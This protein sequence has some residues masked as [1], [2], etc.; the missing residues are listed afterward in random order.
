MSEQVSNRRAAVVD[1]VLAAN[2][3]AQ[4]ALAQ[5]IQTGLESIHRVLGERPVSVRRGERE[6]PSSHPEAE[7]RLR[8]RLVSNDLKAWERPTVERAL[9]AFESARSEL[10]ALVE[11]ARPLQEE[12][13]RLRWSRFFLVTSSAGGHIHRDQHCS[14]CH[15]TTRYGWLPELSGLTEKDAVEAEGPRLCSV[16]FPSAPLEWTVGEEKKVDP[17]VCLG[18]GKPARREGRYYRCAICGTG[19]RPSASGLASRHHR[20]PA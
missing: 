7:A 18:S 20:A 19:V 17:K 4:F 10:A 6:W 13:G 8:A 9:A 15:L 1:R 12:Y 3:E 16:C 2:A 5:K 14:T 11:V